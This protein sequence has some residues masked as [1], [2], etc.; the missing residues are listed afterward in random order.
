MSL[1]SE[2]HV[3]HVWLKDSKTLE[4]KKHV[5]L[6]KELGLMDSIFFVYMLW[7]KLLLVPCWS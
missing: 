4:S 2:Y 6:M 7:S 3:L 1:W 5:V